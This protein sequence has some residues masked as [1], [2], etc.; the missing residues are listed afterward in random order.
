MAADVFNISK[1]K[2][3]TDFS[4]SFVDFPAF[5]YCLCVHLNVYC[6]NKTRNIK[7]KLN[8]CRIKGKRS[9][10]SNW[11]GSDYMNDNE[12]PHS[13]KSKDDKDKPKLRK[14]CRWDDKHL[15]LGPSFDDKSADYSPIVHFPTK[16]ELLCH[17]RL[18]KRI[19][20]KNQKPMRKCNC[21][22]TDFCTTLTPH[23]PNRFG[24][25]LQEDDICEEDE[26]EIT[27]DE[28]LWESR[29]V[30]IKT[31][32]FGEGIDERCTAPLLFISTTSF[33][34]RE[35]TKS[36]ELETIFE[37]KLG[38]SKS[39]EVTPEITASTT[40]EISEPPDED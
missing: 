9:I 28:E 22:N 19:G 11:Y 1:N 40:E 25:R 13:S 6:R 21:T 16:C 29:K 36:M 32:R 37:E 3:F 14:P 39:T 26:D 2:N 5:V 8:Y 4:I 17:P 7:I 10:K 12:L 33:D 18:M 35:Y 38:K 24:C 15:Y 34:K 31:N 30:T 20:C 27:S 23:R